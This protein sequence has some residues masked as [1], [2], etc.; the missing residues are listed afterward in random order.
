M[1]GGYPKDLDP[2]SGPF[3]EIVDAH[4]DVYISAAQTLQ[5]FLKAR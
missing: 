5:M 3:M 4:S 1:G 2:S